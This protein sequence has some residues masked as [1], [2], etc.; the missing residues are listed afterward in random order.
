MGMLHVLERGEFRIWL[1]C[2]KEPG[3]WRWALPTMLYDKYAHVRHQGRPLCDIMC[4]P[5][6]LW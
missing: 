1:R 6:A 3:M 5:N 4:L 2:D